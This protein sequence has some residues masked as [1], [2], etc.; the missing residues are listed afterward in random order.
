MDRFGIYS[1]ICK[2]GYY[3][4]ALQENC[5]PCDVQCVSCMQPGFCTQCIKKMFVV[6]PRVETTEFTCSDWMCLTGYERT[7]WSEFLSE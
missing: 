5:L 7:Y 6:M 1:C 4:P 2:I 3:R